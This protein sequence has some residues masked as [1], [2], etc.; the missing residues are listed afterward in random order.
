MPY[1]AV[2]RSKNT[3]TKVQNMYL[4]DLILLMAAVSKRKLFID[5]DLWR[6]LKTLRQ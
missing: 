2:C 4:I 5:N 6:F 3:L 1:V